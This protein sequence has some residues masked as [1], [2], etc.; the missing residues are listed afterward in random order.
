M[1]LYTFIQTG[2]SRL[3]IGTRDL[4]LVQQLRPPAADRYDGRHLVQGQLST[5]QAAYMVTGQTI[6]PISLRGD[7]L[8]FQ[9]QRL[10]SPLA[11]VERG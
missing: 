11:N 4:A 1:G 2:A 5:R 9:G 8:G 10:L 3:G 7:G 6:R